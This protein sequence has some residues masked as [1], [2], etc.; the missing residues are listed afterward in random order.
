MGKPALPQ[1]AGRGIDCDNP[2]VFWYVLRT[3]KLRLM[4]DSS[5]HKEHGFIKREW[6]C[7]ER[8]ASLINQAQNVDF[9]SDPD[10]S[11]LYVGSHS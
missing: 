11:K 1:A 2:P 6:W 8:C 4:P 9:H 7:E 3:L 10:S 5:I